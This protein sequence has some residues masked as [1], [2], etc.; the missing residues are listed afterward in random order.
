MSGSPGSYAEKKIVQ[1]DIKIYLVT[2]I[3][4]VSLRPFFGN[5]LA[6]PDVVSSIGKKYIRFAFKRS[7]LVDNDTH[8]PMLDNFDCC[9]DI[10]CPTEV[11]D[12]PV[13]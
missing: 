12:Q 9:C 4:A 11:K 7:E 13:L 10:H 1:G 8:L 5:L 2:L 6:E 3:Y